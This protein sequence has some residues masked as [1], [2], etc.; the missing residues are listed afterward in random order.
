MRSHHEPTLAMLATTLPAIVTL[1]W[2]RIR[3]GKG[4]KK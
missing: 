2:T 3:V 4:P 1:W